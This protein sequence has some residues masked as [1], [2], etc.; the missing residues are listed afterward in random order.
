MSLED[1]TIQSS[2]GEENNSSLNSEEKHRVTT[3]IQPVDGHNDVHVHQIK[4]ADADE[5]A[6]FVAGFDGEVTDEQSKK[7]TPVCQL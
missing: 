5:A 6:K 3:S 1:A 4:L 7:G 2:L